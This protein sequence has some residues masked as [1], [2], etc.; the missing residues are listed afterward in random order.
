VADGVE[1]R[2]LAVVDVTHDGHYRRARRQ[3]GRIVGG[4][5]HAL[6][7]VGFGDALDGVSQFLG[8][9]LSGVGVDHVVDLRHLA[10]LHQQLDDVDGALS[11]AVGEIGDADE[12][13]N[14]DLADELL[15]RLVAEVADLTAVAAAE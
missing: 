4:V 9:E 12:L 13:R 7:D 15:L 2:G 10:L 6:F 1:Q 11:H 5:E 8:D 14:R 3:Q